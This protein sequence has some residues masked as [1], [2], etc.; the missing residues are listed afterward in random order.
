MPQIELEV[1]TVR[2]SYMAVWVTRDNPPPRQ[3][4][5]RLRCE[6]VIPVVRL[7]EN[8]AW[9]FI[10]LKVGT[11]DATSPCDYSQGLDAGTSRIV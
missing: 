9:L 8:P 11:H 4:Y 6:K 5:Q 7:K 10:T 2:A 1:V 3:L